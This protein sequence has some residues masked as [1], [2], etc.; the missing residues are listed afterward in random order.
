MQRAA[1]EVSVCAGCGRPLEETSVSAGAC[2]FCL[3][4]VGI[5][6]EAGLPQDSTPNDFKG[7]AHFGVYEIERRED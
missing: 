4:R 7:D 6:G 1:P 5:D 3:L 2:T